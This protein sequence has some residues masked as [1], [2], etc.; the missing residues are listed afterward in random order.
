M[1]VTVGD[2]PV[3]R[4]R[5]SFGRGL[6][7]ISAL[8]ALW[9]LGYVV[10]V[11]IDNPLLLNDSLYYAMQAGR[12]ADGDWFRHALT[13]Q[14][15]AEHPP[16]TSLYL[17]PWSLGG[18]DIIRRQRLAI[19]VLGCFT[20]PVVGVAARSLWR[21][22][23][24]PTPLCAERVGLAAATIAAIYPPL[25]INDLVVMS[26]TPAM[27]AVAAALWA[28]GTY[29]AAPT[30]RRAAL[31][32]L[33]AGLATLTRSE[34]A[35]CVVGFAVVIVA[36]ADRPA[37]R[38]AARS[39]LVLVLAGFMTVAPWVLYNLVR[40]E[41]RT[42]LSTNDGTTLL[43]ANCDTTY[44]DDVGNWNIWC[45]GPFETLPDG[46]VPVDASEVSTAR[47]ALAFDYVRANLDRVPVVVAARVGRL[48]DVYGLRSMV[49]ND[50]GEDKPEWAVWSAVV[51]WWV[52]AAAAVVGWWRLRTLAAPVRWWLLVPPAVA[53]VTAMLFYGAHRIRAPAEPAVVILAAVGVAQ[54]FHR[55]APATD[56]A[57]DRST[58]APDV[59]SG[60]TIDAHVDA[61]G[62][63][64]RVA[65]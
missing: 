9:R 15:G 14:P 46:E 22:I 52:A 25:W 49:A 48:L 23:R 10:L 21:T 36:T 27:L 31:I 39:A 19:A 13:D 56:V 5:W 60:G 7:V 37:R 42:L 18:G 16:L 28:A 62:R 47:R 40:F 34:L 17:T 35:L 32:G 63:G 4:A 58:W 20:V 55:R 44:Y 3:R 45:L 1:D 30:L 33:L 53:L 51:A 29:L 24:R 43:G 11:T 61:G 38:H 8:A 41:D 12:N 6:L 64:R 26:E 59:P 2:L 50:V 57:A 65:R 54:L